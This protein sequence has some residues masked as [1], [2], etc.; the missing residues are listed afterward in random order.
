MEAAKAMANRIPAYQGNDGIFGEEGSRGSEF[1]NP[2]PTNSRHLL[3]KRKT[4]PR[5]GKITG[6]MAS[7]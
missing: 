7:G 1:L 6:R 2:A 4:A 3:D 5:A